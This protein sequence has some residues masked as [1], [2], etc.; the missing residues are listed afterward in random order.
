METARHFLQGELTMITVWTSSSTVLTLH[1]AQ[2]KGPFT[3]RHSTSRRAFG[4]ADLPPA[5][6]QCNETSVY[7]M[8]GNADATR[9]LRMKA[10]EK[11]ALTL[12]GVNCRLIRYDVLPKMPVNMQRFESRRAA[13]K[14]A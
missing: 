13:P 4:R 2:Q 1:E 7:V 5:Q 12:G 9:G 3:W 11:H 8:S 10:S 14:L 6:S